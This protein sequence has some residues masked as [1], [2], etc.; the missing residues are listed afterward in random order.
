VIRVRLKNGFLLL[1]NRC[2]PLEISNSDIEEG[3]RRCLDNAKC[4][5]KDARLLLKNDS[6]G[7]AMFLVVSSAEETSKALIYAGM[8]SGLWGTRKAKRD[9][10]S[11]DPK[12]DLFISYITASAMEDV[13][14]KRRNRVFHP[15]RP[16]NPLDIDN[17][18][19]MAQNLEKAQKDLWNE[20][21]A[22]LYVDRRD[23]KWTSP[24]EI[25]KSKVETWL[26]SAERFLHDTEF[27][28]RNILKATKDMAAQY[29]DWLQNVLIPFSKDYLQSSIDE[30]YADKVISKRL[31]EKLKKKN[32]STIKPL[33]T[34]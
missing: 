31:Y 20:R 2:H 17:F 6:A 11:H 12:L 7:H 33:E 18:V 22:A 25:A 16:D 3:V 21:L 27:Q 19:E 32:A 29:H 23:G 30:L 26:E 8:K 34:Q 14:A 4:L 5:L 10:V 1:E 9:A 15:E 24:S 13:F 28:T